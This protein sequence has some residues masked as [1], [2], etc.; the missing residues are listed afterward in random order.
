[1]YT[2]IV[3]III[4]IR[5]RNKTYGKQ[6]IRSAGFILMPAAHKASS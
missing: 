3:K 1:M 6:L 2:E 4:S 5:K